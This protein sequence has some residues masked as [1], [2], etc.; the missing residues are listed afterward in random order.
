M[1]LLKIAPIWPS[2]LT[3]AL[4]T[5]YLSYLLKAYSPVNRTG[6]PPSGL[7]TSSNLT[8]VI[9]IITNTSK[10]KITYTTTTNIKH[11]SQKIVFPVLPLC[12]RAHRART[13][14]YRLPFNLIDQYQFTKNPCIGRQ[15][16]F[17]PRKN[18]RTKSGNRFS[19]KWKWY[20]YSGASRVLFFV[21]NVPLSI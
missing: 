8:Q 16:C 14:W 21:L 7:F 4:K 19:D 20:K 5:N 17:V 12:T 18:V 1:Y 11:I 3:G 10:Q 13:C 15:K 2:Q 9:I 6:S